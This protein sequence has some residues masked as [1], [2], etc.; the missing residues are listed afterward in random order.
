[1]FYGFGFYGGTGPYI[2]ANYDNT[3]YNSVGLPCLPQTPNT[4]KMFQNIAPLNPY[5]V[6][7]NNYNPNQPTQPY[8]VAQG[9]LSSNNPNLFPQ[10]LTNYYTNVFNP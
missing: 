9:S 8:V 2:N 1:V 5:L 10:N 4:T 7:M 3:G 6:N